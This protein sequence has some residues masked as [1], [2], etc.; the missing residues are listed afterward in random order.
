MQIK[1]SVIVL[2]LTALLIMPLASAGFFDFI[3]GKASSQP[4]DVNVP[5]GNTAPTVPYVQASLSDS[6]TEENYT[7]VVFH[8]YVYDHDFK[9]DINTSSVTASF[10]KDATV[11][12]TTC[13]SQVQVDP[14][15]YDFT[16]TIRMWYWDPAATDY[17]VS[18]TAYDLS[19]VSGSNTSETFSYSQLKAFKMSPDTLIWDTILPGASNSK[20]NNDPTLLN[21]TGN[22][23]VGLGNISINATDVPGQTVPTIKIFG[24]NFTAYGNDGSVCASGSQLNT[25]SYVSVSDASL[26]AGNISAGNGQEQVYYCIP[27]AGSDLTKQN[28]S[29]TTPWQV[30]IV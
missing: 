13:G 26:P 8:V 11:R 12:S 15:T 29:T 7:D 4:T 22:A 23:N 5:V 2:A 3:T 30:K 17:A 18:V 25:A 20:A 21:N 10:T 19:G 9:E 28:Y 1:K 24:N 6:P 14:K 27:A 16:C